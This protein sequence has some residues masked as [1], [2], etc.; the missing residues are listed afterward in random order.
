MVAGGTCDVVLAGGCRQQ[1]DPTCLVGFAN[2][3]ALSA[4]GRSRPFDTGRDGLAAAEAAAVLVLEP[5]HRARARGARVYMTI[6]GAAATSDAHHV[7]APAP[8]G[9]GA[10]RCM[11]LALQ[12][13]GIS[14]RTSLR[15]TPTGRPPRST[16]P[17][18]RQRCGA[19]SAPWRPPVTSIKGVTGHSF[20]AAGAVEAVA[21]AL[22]IQNAIVPPTAGHQDLDD[23]LD[24]DVPTSA[25][26]WTP[27]PVLS[28]SFGFGGHNAVLVLSPH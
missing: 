18:K 11:E 20:G 15:S 2:M 21:V 12:D 28:N 6:G 7:T 9:A 19:C 13:A 1:P 26:P 25:L 27:G 3:R 5:L 4:S 22:S 8:H 16:T 14:A 17:Q 23:T 10:L 24:V